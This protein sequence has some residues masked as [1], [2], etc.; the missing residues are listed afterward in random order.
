MADQVVEQV[1]M[2]ALQE[3]E[4]QEHQ[5]KDLLV[6]IVIQAILTQEAAAEEL[7]LLD[8]QELTIAVVLM[9]KVE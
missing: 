8:T 7:G 6:V 5:D 4:E 1:R 2:V 9:V 3:Q